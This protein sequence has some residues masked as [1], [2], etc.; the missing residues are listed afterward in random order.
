MF[1]KSHPYDASDARD[2]K[3]GG[4][5]QSGARGNSGQGPHREAS[6]DDIIVHPHKGALASY[7]A[8][9]YCLA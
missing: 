2:A 5:C 6:G 9:M 8:M 3:D 7:D 4:E 1:V